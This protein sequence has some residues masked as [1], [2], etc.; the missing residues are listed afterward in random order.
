MLNNLFKIRANK[1][2][3]VK[4]K[5]KKQINIVKLGI[6]NYIVYKNQNFKN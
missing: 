4:Y 5:H 6:F 3:F 2:V 1:I